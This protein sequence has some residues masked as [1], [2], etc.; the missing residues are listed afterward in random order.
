MRYQAALRP[1]PAILG[2]GTDLAGTADWRHALQHGVYPA[3]TKMLCQ[4]YTVPKPPCLSPSFAAMPQSTMRILLDEL[5]S[6]DALELVDQLALPRSWLTCSDPN[7]VS[8]GELALAMAQALFARLA[9]TV[10]EAMRYIE[11]AR[12]QGRS[13]TFD[14]GAVRTVLAPCCGALPCGEA[15][16][17]RI[18][19]P[20]GYTQAGTYPLPRLGMTGRAYIHIDNPQGIPQFFVSELHPEGFSA[21]FQQT[22]STVLRASRDPLGPADHDAMQALRLEGHLAFDTARQLLPALLRCFE[23]QH[24]L[25]SLAQYQ[26]LLRESAEMAWISTEGQTFNHATDRVDDVLELAAQLRAEGFAIK[27]QV[28]VSS[29]GTVRQTAL[30]A[31]SVQRALLEEDGPRPHVLPGSF[32]E[33]ISRDARPGGALPADMD[34]R[35]DSGNA[36]G[37]FKMTAT[38]P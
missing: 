18:L 19:L 7:A 28:E 1:E 23:R 2:Y 38:S 12:K 10:P 27:D 26:L 24:P 32:F 22:V 17:T 30:R 9:Q 35:F 33:F 31:A 25:P 20:L 15:A 14:H 3:G 21:A 29:S 37:I 4:F 5:L 8:R 16:V 13:I 6:A 34:M 11:R 36:T